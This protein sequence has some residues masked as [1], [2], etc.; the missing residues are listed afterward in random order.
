MNERD[1]LQTTNLESINVHF[2]LICLL[3]CIP[4]WLKEMVILDVICH[5]K[6]SL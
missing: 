2:L 1:G 6:H 3:T 4:T 5:M